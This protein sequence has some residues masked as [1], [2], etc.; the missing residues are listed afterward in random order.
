ME[1][2]GKAGAPANQL[3]LDAL[4]EERG[5]FLQNDIV[6]TLGEIGDPRSL[7]ERSSRGRRT[8]DAKRHE[9]S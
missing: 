5:S 7:R 2:L 4:R 3:L 6:K 8:N 9:C 1:L